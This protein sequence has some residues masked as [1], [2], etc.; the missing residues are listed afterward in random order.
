[1][2]LVPHHS[3]DDRQQA[4]TVAILE[5]IAAELR[6][7]DAPSE[8]IEQLTGSIAFAVTA[9]LDDSTSVDFAD[10]EISPMLTFQVGNE[11]LAYAGGN[12]WMHEYVY[13]LLPS[14]LQR[15]SDTDD[16]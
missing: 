4:L 10:G 15:M 12:T 9:L 13:R 16:V 6:K 11:E 2:K 7:V 1:M 14:V 8:L 3:F 5:A